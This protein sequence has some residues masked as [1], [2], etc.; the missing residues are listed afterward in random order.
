MPDHLIAG[1]NSL[2]GASQNIAALRIFIKRAS[3]SDQNVLIQG[4]TGVGKELAARMIHIESERVNNPFLKVNSAN[5][6]EYLLESELFGHRRGAFTGAMC[7]KRGLIEEADKGTF[8]L[9]EIGDIKASLQSKLLSVLEDKE[10]RPVGHTKA[11]K[12]DVHFIFASNKDL[13]DEVDRG[14]FRQDLYYRISILRFNLLPLRD[15]KEDIPILAENMIEKLN[16]NSG[17][18][19]RIT[20]AAQKRLLAHSF[21]GNVRELE[22][23]IKRAYILSDRGVID[24]EDFQIDKGSRTILYKS[25]EDVLFDEMV[26]EK[27]SFW[28]VIHKPFIA[29]ELNRTEVNRVLERGLKVT[30]GTYKMLLPL[31]NIDDSEAEYKRFMKLIKAHRL[32]SKK[33]NRHDSSRSMGTDKCVN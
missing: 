30:G 9:D 4:E 25:N 29:R 21:P 11:K 16:K 2:L 1:D 14:A 22:S 17:L 13:C 20:E 31:F 19:K 23:I 33:N 28:D 6:N 3:Q 8:F 18:R 32:Y 12:V 10:V 24:E 15:R 7:D 27:R 5:L 26:K